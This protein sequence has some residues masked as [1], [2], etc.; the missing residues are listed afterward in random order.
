[1]QKATLV[2]SW[3]NTDRSLMWA[4]IMSQQMLVQCCKIGIQ[5]KLDKPS[6]LAIP[7]IPN[8]VTKGAEIYNLRSSERIALPIPKMR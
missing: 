5:E 6:K 1:M 8:D 7:L 4:I 2:H 3:K